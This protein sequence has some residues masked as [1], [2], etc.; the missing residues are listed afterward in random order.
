MKNG[1]RRDGRTG[2]RAV[3]PDGDKV[4]DGADDGLDVVAAGDARFTDDELADYIE[5]F[6]S[7]EKVS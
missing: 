2:L 4:L 1:A 3:G 6:L 5:P 7:V